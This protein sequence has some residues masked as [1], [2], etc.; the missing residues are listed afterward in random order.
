MKPWKFIALVFVVTLAVLFGASCNDDKQYSYS[1]ETTTTVR[2]T[3]YSPRHGGRTYV[4]E[5]GP[6][7]HYEYVEYSWGRVTYHYTRDGREYPDYFYYDCMCS[8]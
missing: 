3:E 1:E 8:R 2:R 4:F 7:S 5:S 6:Y